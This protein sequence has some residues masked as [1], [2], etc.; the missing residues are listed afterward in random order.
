M[1]KIIRQGQKEPTSITIG[2]QKIQVLEFADELNILGS[3]L[4][5]TKKTAQVL[6]NAD[7]KVELKIIRENKNIIKLLENEKDMDND[8]ED[9]IF[10]KVNQFQYLGA[11]LTVK[12]DCS[13]VI[14][15][16]ITK[17]ERA[18][19]HYVSF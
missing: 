17:D 4:N 11:M 13:R 18:A 12:N 1:E 5:D 7:G 8:D 9:A 10:E 19:L 6:V 14:V 2:E 15:I 3:S 16:R